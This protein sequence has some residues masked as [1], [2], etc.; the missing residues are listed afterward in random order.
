MLNILYSITG[1][2]QE[3]NVDI[4]ADFYIDKNNTFVTKNGDEYSTQYLWVEYDEQQ[5]RYVA[6]LS[7][8]TKY[9]LE[10]LLK[11]HGIKK[12]NMVK[13]SNIKKASAKTLLK[14]LNEI[15][16]TYPT[17]RN[18]EKSYYYILNFIDGFAIQCLYVNKSEN[19]INTTPYTT[20]FLEIVPVTINKKI[21]I[22]Y[23]FSGKFCQG[24]TL[25]IKNHFY[26]K[27]SAI[28]TI[29]N[30]G[31]IKD[32]E[33]LN[34]LLRSQYPC[35]IFKNNEKYGLKSIG[36]KI[37]IE[38]EYDSIKK[39]SSFIAGY[40]RGKPDL[41]F[42]NGEAIHIKGLRSIYVDEKWRLSALVDN[43]IKWVDPD[44]NLTETVTPRLMF[45]CG[46]VPRISVSI[47]IKDD[48]Y[49]YNELYSYGDERITEHKIAPI[50]HYKSMRFLNGEI[51]YE[52][53]SSGIQGYK[54]PE[55]CYIAETATG[56]GIVQIKNENKNPIEKVLI[57][58]EQNKFYFK[59]FNYPIKF[60]SKEVYGF[61]PQN[62]K[63][64]YS[65][66]KEF[67]KGFARFKMPD[68]IQGWLCL[69]GKEYFDIQTQ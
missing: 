8:G 32:K 15:E 61:W 6:G 17:E 34:K 41:H 46:T 53:M 56:Q 30:Q 69:D 36:D 64:K 13:I 25:P 33:A 1:F 47:I 57:P 11:N 42:I 7:S 40:K 4:D 62:T 54:L 43:T 22:L 66:L 58:F 24:Y 52:Y 5:K 67:E 12:D 65:E 68:G 50:S 20:T 44:G 63:A 27:L 26:T 28:N 59:G 45:G 38:A 31:A 55:S 23:F 2:A 14:E 16:F 49:T 10:T 18:Y 48:Y 9:D 37:L 35:E 3:I 51:K 19:S 21:T 29:P 39:V 60:E